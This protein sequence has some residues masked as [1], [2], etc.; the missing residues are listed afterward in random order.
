MLSTILSAVLLESSIACP[1]LPFIPHPYPLT[2][3]PFLPVFRQHLPQSIDALFSLLLSQS[4]P[5]HHK[6]LRHVT[7]RGAY[8]SLP[9]HLPP[10]ST[11]FQRHAHRVD[12]DTHWLAV[13][14]ARVGATPWNNKGC[15]ASSS[16]YFSSSLV[17][18]A[19]CLP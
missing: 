17:L 2:Y 11:H 19:R 1:P 14:P 18:G 8:L 6:R 4:V 16:R 10:T 9:Y 7:L 13:W 15:H 12:V 5:V 3:S